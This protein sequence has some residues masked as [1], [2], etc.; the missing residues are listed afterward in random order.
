MK[1]LRNFTKITL[2]VYVLVGIKNEI[3]KFWSLLTAYIYNRHFKVKRKEKVVKILSWLESCNSSFDYKTQNATNKAVK[4]KRENILIT[5]TT[6]KKC[7][8]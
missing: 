3:I 4:V 1:N 8:F 7:F 5:Y 2:Q 6:L